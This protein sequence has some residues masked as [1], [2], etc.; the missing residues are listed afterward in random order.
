MADKTRKAL[1]K[2]ALLL[3]ISKDEVENAQN[4]ST[5]KGLI[6][7]FGKSEELKEGDLVKAELLGNLKI[8]GKIYKKG[9]IFKC[10]YDKDIKDLLINGVIKSI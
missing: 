3:G 4:K 10:R 9:D 2:E 1:E 5:L 8:N 6:S 7:N